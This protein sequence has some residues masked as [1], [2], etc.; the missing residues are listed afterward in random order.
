[1]DP[2]E[3]RL[4]FESDIP[5]A[6]R[7]KEAA[8]WNQTEADWRRLI[9]LEPN[10]CF[11]AIENDRLVGT[12]TTTTYQDE[13]AWIGMVLV[14][15]QHRRRGIATRLMETALA[16]LGEKVAVIKLDATAEGKPVYEKFG[17][18]AE[19][20]VERWRGSVKSQSI[21]RENA[22]I[23]L[24]ELLALDRR[25]FSADR[26]RLITSLIDDSRTS[27]VLV[28]EES[29]SLTGY[30][31]A[32]EGTKAAYIG[33]MAT[34]DTAQVENLLDRILVQLSGNSVYI[35]FSSECGVSS[36]MLAARGFV[37]ERDLIRMSCGSRSMKTSPLVIAIA[38]PE[39]G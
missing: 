7:L 9:N 23:N 32:R 19:S 38:G 36:S 18:K 1:M 37:K 28:T 6:M 17:F 16:Y 34:T 26:S 33:P 22:A 35:D 39:I 12:T 3:I 14:D 11:A 21:E 25:V 15:P 2:V 30:A 31:L 20:L 8:G 27:P 10:G 29:G 5:A 13:L 4:L 24:E